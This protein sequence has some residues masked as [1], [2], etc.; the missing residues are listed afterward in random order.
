MVG[1][2]YDY[3]DDFDIDANASGVY[4]THKVT[5]S[6]QA[7]IRAQMSTSSQTSDPIKTFAYVAH[8]AV[9]G[10]LEVP[11]HYIKGRG[12]GSVIGVAHSSV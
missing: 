7:W 2:G 10:P 6:V 8:E 12:W 1:H 5:A 4:T 9:H 11:L 3:H